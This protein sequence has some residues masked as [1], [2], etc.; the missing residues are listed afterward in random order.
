MKKVAILALSALVLAGCRG[1]GIVDKKYENAVLACD[2]GQLEYKLEG[3]PMQFCY[4]PAWGEVSV[5]ETEGF[6]GSEQVVGFSGAGLTP[7]IKVQ[8][9]D[10]KK[11]ADDPGLCFNCMKLTAPDESIAADMAEV[12][13]AEADALKV[14]KADIFGTRA[15]RVNDGVN[16]TYYV[17]GAFDGKNVII[18]ADDGMA[19]EIDNFIWSMIL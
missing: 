15:A 16:I 1:E 11:S 3:T 9:G 18:E 4:D 7:T 14:R 8:S 12:L 13:G 10:F 17:P 6:A 2:E 19:E 5:T